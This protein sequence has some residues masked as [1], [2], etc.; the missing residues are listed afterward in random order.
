[1]NEFNDYAYYNYIYKESTSRFNLKT[2]D[3]INTEIKSISNIIDL[4]KS[5]PNDQE[6]G[7]KIREL[8]NETI[9]IK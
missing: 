4:V 7:A 2:K 6:L 1:M 3:H 9:N 5:T 8:I